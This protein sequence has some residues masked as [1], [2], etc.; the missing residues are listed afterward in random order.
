[1]KVKWLIEIRPTAATNLRNNV[2]VLLS[3]YIVYTKP[4][5]TPTISIKLCFALKH[6]ISCIITS[7][8]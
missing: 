7:S 1:M 3:I 8:V 5:P 4:M 2:F 6:E